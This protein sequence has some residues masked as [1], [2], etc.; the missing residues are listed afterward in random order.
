M[1]NKPMINIDIPIH[2][3][4]VLKSWT[5]EFVAEAQ[6]NLTWMTQDEMQ[7]TMSKLRVY[8]K[9][10]KFGSMTHPLHMISLIEQTETQARSIMPH[11]VEE[12]KIVQEWYHSL[13]YS[14]KVVGEDEDG[15]LDLR[16][17]TP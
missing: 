6:T 5:N 12:A 16:I 10:E 2:V 3:L 4:E 8:Q 13:G 15:T 7:Q 11:H 17:K 14:A 9:R 1:I